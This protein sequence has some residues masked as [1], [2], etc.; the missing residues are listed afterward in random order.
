M[1]LQCP[2]CG[3]KSYIKV[4]GTRV[5]KTNDMYQLTTNTSVITLSV[6]ILVKLW[7][8]PYLKRQTH[9]GEN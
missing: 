9:F 6:V 7:K 1:L 3:S 5:L 4:P 8:S 2:S